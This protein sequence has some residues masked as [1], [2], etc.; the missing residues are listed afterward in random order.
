M[1]DTHTG[2]QGTYFSK[3]AVLK[4][5][6]ASRLLAWVVLGVYG[7]QLLVSL[8][9]NILLI[10]QG[11]W[12]GMRFIDIFQNFLYILQEPLHGVVYFFALM[13]VAQLLLVFLDVE[14]NTRRAARWQEKNLSTKAA[15]EDL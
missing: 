5:S 12:A 11:Q 2:F 9:N 14:D 7:V 1:K 4:I 6:Q 8:G 15:G 13:G 3:E 10:L